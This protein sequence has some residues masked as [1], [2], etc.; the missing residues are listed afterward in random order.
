MQSVDP[1]QTPSVA[2]GLCL[3]CLPKSLLWNAR[4]TSFTNRLFKHAVVCTLG[5]LK[6]ALHAV[7]SGTLFSMHAC[8][9]YLIEIL[10]QK[11]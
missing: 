2:S 6:V 1:D 8:L 4:L 5:H 3:H 11:V 9:L 10:T 7:S